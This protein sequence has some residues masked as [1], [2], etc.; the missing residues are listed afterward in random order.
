LEG[1]KQLQTRDKQ[2]EMKRNHELNYNE[3]MKLEMINH[4]PE[5]F[6]ELWQVMKMAWLC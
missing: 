2:K 4:L 3:K 5:R 6:V 1:T